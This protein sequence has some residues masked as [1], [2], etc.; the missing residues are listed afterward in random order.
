M[1][2]GHPMDEGTWSTALGTFR[3]APSLDGA[4]VGTNIEI[5]AFGILEKKTLQWCAMVDGRQVTCCYNTNCKNIAHYINNIS[6]T[7]GTNIEILAFNSLGGKNL[8]CLVT[9]TVDF[10]QLK[11]QVSYA[12]S[13]RKCIGRDQVFKRH[14]SS[15]MEEELMSRCEKNVINNIKSL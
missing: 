2:L 1:I 5:L 8:Q 6:D 11:S 7:V 12:I 10:R 14:A 13:C 15:H 4:Y 3:K 9:E